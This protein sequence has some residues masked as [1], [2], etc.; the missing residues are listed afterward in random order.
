MIM[1]NLILKPI[2]K[3][4]HLRAY[5]H[6]ENGDKNEINHSQMRKIAQILSEC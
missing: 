4:F 2:T 1:K 5:P 6:F 3:A